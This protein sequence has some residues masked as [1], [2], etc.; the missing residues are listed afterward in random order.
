[1]DRQEVAME[2]KGWQVAPGI[3]RIEAPLDER[4]VACHLIVGDDA[5]LLIDT[6]VA[7]TVEGSIVPYMAA[8]GLDAAN[9]RWIVTTHPDVDHMGGNAAAKRAFPGVTIAAHE[10]D[11]WLIEDVE[12]IVVERYSEFA[13]DHGIEVDDGT[14]RWCLAVATPAPVDLAV[15]GGETIRLGPD[16]P[17]ELLH[18]PGHS[19]GSLSV[20]DPSTRSALVGDAVLGG[21][22]HAADGAPAA[23]PTYRYP[24]AYRSTIDE[25]SQRSPDR[26]LAAHEPVME[27]AA[28]RSFLEE[29]HLFTTRLETAALAA[30]ADRARGLTTRELV[31]RV[32]TLVGGWP[33]ASAERLAA[34]LVGHL[35]ELSESGRVE[36]VIGRRGIVRWQYRPAILAT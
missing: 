7:A 12:R 25:L 14:R 27:H 36:A 22:V 20:W 30:L 5:A 28:V 6:G 4:F 3:H 29:S 13:V 32:G 31:E 19:W 34:P 21:A 16:R 8:I 11:V 33:G 10:E 2:G 24:S 17:V 26:L 18:T 15:R 9:L 1:M 35:E 23:P